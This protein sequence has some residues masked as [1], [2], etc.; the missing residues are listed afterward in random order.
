MKQFVRKIVNHIQK[1]FY[2][3]FISVIIRPLKASVFLTYENSGKLDGTGA[4][5][6]RLIATYGVAKFLGFKHL[7]SGIKE[8]AIHPLDPFQTLAEMQKFTEHTNWVFELPSD[9]IPSNPI[10]IKGASLNF[11]MIIKAL[12]FS[13]VKKDQVLILC[14]DPYSIA[15]KFPSIYEIAVMDL[16]NWKPYLA[17][18]RF[19]HLPKEF[20]ALHYRQG[21][22]DMTVQAGEKFSRQMPLDYFQRKL[23]EWCKLN[24]TKI[25][26]FTD[27]PKTDIEYMI[28]TSQANLWSTNPRVSGGNMSILTTDFTSISDKYG[29]RLHIISGGN[30]L[31]A[32]AIMSQ[33]QILVIG[34]SSLSY[35]AGLLN[36]S[37]TVIAPPNFWHAPLRS[38]IKG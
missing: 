14:S 30:P 23:E 2:L 34:R 29:S 33:A 17:S 26:M 28:P 27:A 35:V 36:S 19:S 9:L 4:Q 13:I 15:D 31:E 11:K 22:G 24:L 10:E 16:I 1:L 5:V 21:V 7:Y 18:E 8:I 3:T 12:Y 37:G 20:V 25:Y 32:I 6:Q 38:W